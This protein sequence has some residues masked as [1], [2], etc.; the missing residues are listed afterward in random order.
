MF[1]RFDDRSRKVLAL[2]NQQAQRFNHDYI[3]TEHVLLGLVKEGSGVGANVLKNLD[4]DLRK[5]RIEVEKLTKAGTEEVLLGKLPQTPATKRV[6]NYAVEEAK[7]LNHNYVGTEHLLLGML[8][9]REGIAAQVLFSLG[10]SFEEV[11]EEIRNLLGAGIEDDDGK[12]L[13]PSI[14]SNLSEST[15]AAKI[16]FDLWIDP[17]G[18]NAEDVTALLMALSD[19]HRVVGGTGLKFVEKGL[20]A[21]VT[22]EAS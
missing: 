6:I 10:L 18:A 19:L 13:S 2:A 15:V 1:E 12:P 16:S 21:F 7:S 9:E 17:G 22:E 5:I 3:G 20:G 8:R 14:P 11:K 4:I